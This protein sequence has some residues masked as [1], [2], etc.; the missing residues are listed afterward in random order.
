MTAGPTPGQ[1]ASPLFRSVL[2][3][4]PILVFFV[5][6]AL[7]G[8]D[9][10]GRQVMIATAAFMGTTALAMLVMKLRFDRIS[11]MSWISGLL[12]G[13][14][15]GLTLLFQDDVFIK[16]KPTLVYLM[17]AA[18][19]G[20]GVWTNRPTLQMLLETA[21]PGL[22]PRGWRLLSINW[23]GFFLFMAALNE[24][25]WRTSSWDFWVGFKLWGVLP[26]TLLFAAV[27]IPMLLRHG[28]DVGGTPRSKVQAEADAAPPLQ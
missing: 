12:I 8:G 20:Y 9:D 23:T 10:K 13:V 2:E 16:M 26:L 22:S 14:F 19:L 21:Y 5:V 18:V 24:V 15:G 27:N 28:L 25:V 1:H 3:F 17:F 11:P 6:N 4:G 7:V